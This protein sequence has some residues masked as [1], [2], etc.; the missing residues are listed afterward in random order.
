MTSFKSF[1]RFS[2]ELDHLSQ[3]EQSMHV[4]ELMAVCGDTQISL[5]LTK[6]KLY[7]SC[8]YGNEFIILCDAHF[9]HV[10]QHFLTVFGHFPRPS[11]TIFCASCEPA[12]TISGISSCSKTFKSLAAPF[13]WLDD[14]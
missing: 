13:F 3:M 6:Q 1:S 7:F 12:N 2:F 14:V 10:S 4:K 11:L 5:C 9:G 8:R